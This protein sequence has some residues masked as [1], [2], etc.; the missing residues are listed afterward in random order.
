M[1]PQIQKAAPDF[2]GTAVVNGQFKEIKLSDFQGK[3]LVSLKAII[4]LLE[5]FIKN[6]VCF[7]FFSSIRWTCEYSIKLIDNTWPL[8]LIAIIAS[9]LK[10]IVRGHLIAQLIDSVYNTFHR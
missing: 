1:T 4:D 6:F 10:L 8:L 2:K 9:H 7:R 3:Y 5:I